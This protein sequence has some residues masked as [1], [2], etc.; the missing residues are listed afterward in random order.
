MKYYSSS[1]IEFS[2]KETLASV[3]ST[4][5]KTTLYDSETTMVYEN[6]PKSDCGDNFIILDNFN[7]DY[8]KKI[9]LESC[10]ILFS[11]K[12]KLGLL[13]IFRRSTCWNNLP[14]R[15]D[16]YLDEYIYIYIYIYILTQYT[17]LT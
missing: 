2:H 10:I 8:L 1:L 17:S 9:V 7:D 12:V 16:N 5:N 13:E 6:H 11:L 3:L 4:T 15:Y 14:H